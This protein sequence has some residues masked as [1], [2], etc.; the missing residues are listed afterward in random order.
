MAILKQTEAGM[1][2]PE[3]CRKHGISHCPVYGNHNNPF[4]IIIRIG[5]A[6]TD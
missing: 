3:V 2:V 5:A 4:S 1:S 6:L